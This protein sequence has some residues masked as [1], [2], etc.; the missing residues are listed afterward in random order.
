MSA[1]DIATREPAGASDAPPEGPLGQINVV[2]VGAARPPKSRSG[3]AA[4][5]RWIVC[6][7]LRVPGPPGSE[8]PTGTVLPVAVSAEGG[9]ELM[10]VARDPARSSLLDPN[11]PVLAGQ[12]DVAGFEVVDRRLVPAVTL[13]ELSA[14]HGPIDALRLDCGGLEYQLLATGLPALRDTV[15]LEVDGGLVDNY[16]GQYP[17]ATVS[18]LLEEAGFTLVGLDIRSRRAPGG[19][20]GGHRQPTEYRGL[21]LRDYVRRPDGFSPEQAGKLLVLCEAF[22]HRSFGREVAALLRRDRSSVDGDQ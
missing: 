12:D 3:L 11:W 17:L 9:S 1:I 2:G 13:A 21:W 16:A 6:D 18:L 4:R 14:E 5:C 22:G 8:P 15:C 20:P 7:P 19:A 10:N